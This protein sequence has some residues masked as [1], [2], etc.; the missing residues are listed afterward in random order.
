M[1]RAEADIESEGAAQDLREGVRSGI[2]A[3][4]RRDVE[5][6]GGRTARLLGAAGVL[7]AF[8]AVGATLLVMGHPYGHHP[9]WHVAVFTAAWSALLIVSLALA[10][11]EVRT[12]DL[13]I[14]R[15][16]CVGLLGLGVAGLCGA[17]CPNPHFLTWWFAT[18]AG[19]RLAADYGGPVSV[20]CFGFVT[21]L[22]F[23][24]VAAFAAL[25]DARRG[26][27]KPLLPAVALL[28]L[29]APGLALQSFGTSWAVFAGW[30]LG[31]ATGS[32]TGVVAG[33]RAHS[34]GASDGQ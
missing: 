21:S 24:A 11:L 5:L 2:L 27:I 15:S 22:A 16:A 34:L 1:S 6:R 29:L 19:A 23:G 7:G 31:A 14:A 17:L 3:A 12:P 9:A 10:F 28:I 33:V 26:P 30:I 4:V 25:R 32:Y 18:S 8:G 20:V 13:P